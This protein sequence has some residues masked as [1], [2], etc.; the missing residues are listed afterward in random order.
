MPAHESARSARIAQLCRVLSTQDNGEG[1]GG[2]VVSEENVYKYKNMSTVTMKIEGVQVDVM[3]GRDGKDFRMRRGEGAISNRVASAERLYYGISGKWM[4]CFIKTDKFFEA[5]ADPVSTV[6][7][8]LEQGRTLPTK[9]ITHYRLC[10]IG[11]KRLMT[12]GGD[13]GPDGIDIKL[14]DFTPLEQTRICAAEPYEFSMEVSTPLSRLSSDSHKRRRS[15]KNEENDVSDD[16]S[17]SDDEDTSATALVKPNLSLAA[18]MALVK[19]FLPPDLA[20]S[21]QF[22]S[23][24]ATQAIHQGMDGPALARFVIAAQAREDART[25]AEREK[26][27]AE[28]RRIREPDVR[29]EVEVV[30]DEAFDVPCGYAC[31][32]QISAVHYFVVREGDE[33]T[34][35][36]RSCRLAK[37]KE[38]CGTTKRIMKPSRARCWINRHGR[39]IRGCCHHCGPASRTTI[40]VLLDGWHAGHDEARSKRGSTHEA[41]LAP[42][43]PRCNLDQGV[44]TFEEYNR[45]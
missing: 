34:L 42:L 5:C 44:E 10:G 45:Q 23:F 31:G 40:H 22:I 25:D 2:F 24:A 14:S 27:K 6:G 16:D 30:F 32:A 13:P 8:H 43:H 4:S 17:S 33:F 19:P 12:C 29:A 41:N 28:R 1:L 38:G 7:S 21:E 18:A 37:A 39:N 11:I 35:C 9:S 20:A 15:A 3:P 36:C 26:A